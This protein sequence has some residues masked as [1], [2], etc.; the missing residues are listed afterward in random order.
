[1]QGLYIVGDLWDPETNALESWKD[2][3]DSQEPYTRR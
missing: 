2:V 1:M 3:R